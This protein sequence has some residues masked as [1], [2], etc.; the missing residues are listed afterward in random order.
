[1]RFP[2]PILRLD[3]HQRHWPL[4]GPLSLPLSPPLPWVASPASW[5]LLP[6]VRRVLQ[7]VE[8]GDGERWREMGEM[9]RDGRWREM[10][11]AHAEA[12]FNV[13]AL[14]YLVLR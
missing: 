13:C 1:M 14:V 5:V 4:Q 2:A 9:E 11:H 12:S 10:E 6:P 3:L 8:M 7:P